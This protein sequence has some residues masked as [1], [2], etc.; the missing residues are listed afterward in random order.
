M[1]NNA[2]EN[3]SQFVKYP[4]PVS[5]LPNWRQKMISSLHPGSALEPEEQS[6]SM[7][8]N[9]QVADESLQKK[10]VSGPR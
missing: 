1:G 5:G 3:H 7:N 8:S 4:S 2:A 9:Q 10:N 6:N